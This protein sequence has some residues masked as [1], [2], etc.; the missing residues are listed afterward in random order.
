[1]VPNSYEYVN[2][3]GTEQGEALGFQSRGQYTQQMPFCSAFLSSTKAFVVLFIACALI[4]FIFL[5]AGTSLL[6]RFDK[7]AKG[8][9]QGT[10]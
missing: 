6:E 5:N 2:Q 3:L 1:M 7:R 4:A 9:A 10:P 8:N